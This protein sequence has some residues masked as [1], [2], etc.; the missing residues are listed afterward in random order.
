M[1]LWTGFLASAS[2]PEIKRTVRGLEEEKSEIQAIGTELNAFTTLAPGARSATISLEVRPE[3][4]PKVSGVKPASRLV[5]STGMRPFQSG[6]ENSACCTF[7]QFAARTTMSCYV[8]CCGVPASAQEPSFFTR[9]AS[10]SGPRVL[11]NNTR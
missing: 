8:A 5:V 3:T 6:M 7:G 4:S 10:E 1:R 11:L 2:S 9:G